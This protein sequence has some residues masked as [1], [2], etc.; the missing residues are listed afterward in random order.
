MSDDERF[1]RWIV[2]A[3]A[4]YN[5]PPREV[6]RDAM[7]TAIRAGLQARA[8]PVIAMHPT[9]ARRVFRVVPFLAAAAVLVV[10]AYRAGVSSVTQRP[11]PVVAATP[12]TPAA[13]DTTVFYDMAARA[14]FERADAFLT[15]ARSTLGNTRL[16]T[17]VTTWARE[18]LADTRLLIDSPAGASAEK[19]ALLE[20]LE[21]TLAQIVQL[22]AA[23]TDD[24]RRIV[25]RE[26]R[27]GDLIT[28]LRTSAPA[29]ERGT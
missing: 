21:L 20:D 6:P 24:D 28:R 5:R 22:S 1:D 12:S 23:S 25:G 18:M 9:M 14:H 4:D 27:R 26:L 8:T 11:A 15:T 17:A 7:W 10:V 3:A 29:I 2:D 19:R 13:P 16:D